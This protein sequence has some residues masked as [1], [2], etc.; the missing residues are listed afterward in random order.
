MILTHFRVLIP[1]FFR[2]RFFEG[3][4]FLMENQDLGGEMVCCSMRTQV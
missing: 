3:V 1:S 2:Y 4:I